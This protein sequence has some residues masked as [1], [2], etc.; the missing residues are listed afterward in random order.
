[1]IMV[2]ALHGPCRTAVQAGTCAG[3][4]FSSHS[5]GTATIQSD[6]VRGTQGLDNPAGS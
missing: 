3:V 2:S 4:Q 5:K 6:S 1:M